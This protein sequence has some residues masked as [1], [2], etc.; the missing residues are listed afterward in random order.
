L[1]DVVG[2]ASHVFTKRV[3]AA[4]AGTVCIFSFLCLVL[5]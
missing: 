3:S 5:Y 4:D 1:K 2:L